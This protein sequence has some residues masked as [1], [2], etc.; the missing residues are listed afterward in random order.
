MEAQEYLL[1][2]L[3]LRMFGPHTNQTLANLSVRILIA[4]LL[5]LRPKVIDPTDLVDIIADYLKSG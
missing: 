2:S 4:L 3:I 5:T 1:R